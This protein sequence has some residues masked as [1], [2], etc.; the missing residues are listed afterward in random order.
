MNSRSVDAGLVLVSRYRRGVYMVC[1]AMFDME[2]D[3]GG[4]TRNEA[5]G[6]SAR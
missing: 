3:R 6:S 4:G 5:D 1:S 2:D